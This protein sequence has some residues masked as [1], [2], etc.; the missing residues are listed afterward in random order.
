MTEIELR[1]QPESFVPFY[2]LV[3][4]TDLAYFELKA[5]IAEQDIFTNL[6]DTKLV[7]KI[8]DHHFNPEHKD[9]FVP[10]KSTDFTLRLHRRVSIPKSVAKDDFQGFAMQACVL[11]ARV[12]V[13]RNWHDRLSRD[14]RSDLKEFMHLV[15]KSFVIN[16]NEEP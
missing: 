10:S 9:D 13:E 6:Q 7:L 2:I 4:T 1:P 3:E 8:F 14:Y 5:A 11:G 15:L 12:L 16:D